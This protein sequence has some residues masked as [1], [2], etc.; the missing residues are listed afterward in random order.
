MKDA[1]EAD[2][3]ELTL[4]YLHIFQSIA[5]WPTGRLAECNE[6]GSAK[7]RFWMLFHNLRVMG[8]NIIAPIS[9]HQ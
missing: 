7:T 3:A 9:L 1:L 2:R 5:R 8:T 4:P 6:K